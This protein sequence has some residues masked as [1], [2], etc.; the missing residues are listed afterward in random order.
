M[1]LVKTYDPIEISLSLID[2]LSIIFDDQYGLICTFDSIMSNEN[3]IRLM[4][5]INQ[6]DVLID[7]LLRLRTLENKSK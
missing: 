7:F 3:G 4:N 2:D 1:V 6:H 5:N